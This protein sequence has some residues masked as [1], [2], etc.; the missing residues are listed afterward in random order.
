MRDRS[1]GN[2]AG[3]YLPN[4]AP[5][6]LRPGIRAI[7]LLLEMPCQMTNRDVKLRLRE[8]AMIWVFQKSAGWGVGCAEAAAVVAEAIPSRR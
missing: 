5:V 4:Q 2:E 7:A 3:A 6:C 8:R 1:C